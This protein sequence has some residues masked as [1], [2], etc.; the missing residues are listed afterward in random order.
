MLFALGVWASPSPTYQSP[1]ATPWPRPTSATN[2]SSTIK[3][4]ASSTQVTAASESQLLQD[5]V[6]RFLDQCNDAPSIVLSPI[7]ATS[8]LVPPTPLNIV[9]SVASEDDDLHYGVDESYTLSVHAA[10][11]AHVNASTVFGAMHG[12]QTIL[13]LL[14]RTGADSQLQIRGLPWQISDSPRFAHRGMLVDPGRHFLP[15]DALRKHIDAMSMNKLNVLHLHLTDFQSFPFRPDCA[16]EMANGAYS[17]EEVYTPDDLRGLYAYARARGVRVMAEIDTPGHAASWGA[18][19]PEVVLSDCPA[20]IAKRGDG[21]ATLDPTKD[22]TYEILGLVLEEAGRIMPDS[23]FHLGGDEVRFDCWK[24]SPSIAAYMAQK[25]YGTDY[26]L[27]EAEYMAR[28][29][30]VAADSLPNRTLALYQEVADNKIALPNSVAFVVWKAGGVA[31]GI[32]IPEE[33]EHLVKAGH[34]VIVSNGNDRNWYLNDGWGNGKKVSLWPDV[35]SLDPLNGTELSLEEQKLVIGGEASLWGEEIDES[36]L[37]MKAWP[38]GAAFAERMWSAAE[39]RDEN[40]AA[41]R[42]ARQFCRMRAR[43]TKASPISPGS[44]FKQLPAAES[45]ELLV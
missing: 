45:T 17:P 15:L 28:M 11:A 16:P 9:V 1:D 34:P 27:L 12:L 4:D 8:E 5:A 2:G 20:I 32:S 3:W 22:S 35:Y 7:A 42:L 19:R 10:G 30:A 36:N 37:Q 14:E 25:G 38:R 41:P 39:V 21:F 44:C 13:Q 18:G 33:V 24:E 31:G 40:E 6:G 43:G 29:L 26:S 23:F